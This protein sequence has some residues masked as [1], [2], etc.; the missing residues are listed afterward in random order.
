MVKRIPGWITGAFLLALCLLV[1]YGSGCKE[2]NNS[3][4]I[5]MTLSGIQATSGTLDE[6]SGTFSIKGYVKNDGMPVVNLPVELFVGNKEVASPVQTAGNGQFIF[7]NLGPALYTLRVG[8]GSATFTEMLYPVYVTEDGAQSP[9]DLVIPIELRN[10]NVIPASGTLEAYVVDASTNNPIM[11]A[12]ASLSVYSGGVWVPQNRTTLT[13][14]SGY[15]F[16]SDVLPGLYTL[17][18]QKAGYASMAYPVNLQ[19][20]GAMSPSKPKIPLTF[21]SSVPTITGTISGYAKDVSGKVIP[22]ITITVKDSKTGIQVTGSPR[23]TTTEGKFTFDNLPIGE[24]AI[25]AAGVGYTSVTRTSYIR[26]DGTA[27]P[28]STDL[29]LA[30]ITAITGSL[31]GYVK[32]EN[33]TPL[34]E[35][36]ITVTNINTGL[37]IAGSPRRTTTEGK[38]IFESVPVGDYTV[39]ATGAGYSTA[40]RT[41]YIRSDGTADPVTTQIA[42][43]RVTDIKGTI[44]GFARLDITNAVLPEITVTAKNVG[45]GLF[46]AGSPRKTTSEGRYSFYDLPPGEYTVTASGTGYTEVTRTCYIKTDGAADPPSTDLILS[47]S[48]ASSK[49]EAYVID[50]STNAGIGLADVSLSKYDEDTGLWN[51]LGLNTVTNGSGYFSFSGIDPG[52]YLAAVSKTGYVSRDYAITIKEDG[53]KD[54]A[55]PRITLTS[56]AQAIVGNVVGTVKLDTTGLA[57]PEISVSLKNGSNAHVTGSPLKTTAD[58][59]FGFYG[60]VPG[61]YTLNASGTNYTSVTRTCYILNNGTSDPTSTN[62][63]LSRDPA[64]GNIIGYVKY[65]TAALPEISVTVR[66]SNGDQVASSPFITTQDGK[67][68]AYDLG[69]GVYTISVNAAG[70]LPVTRTVY[71]A[72]NGIVDPATSNISLTPDPSVVGTVIGYVR[73]ASTSAAIPEVDV[74]LEDSNGDPVGGTIKTTSEGK[75]LFENLRPDTYSIIVPGTVAGVP[76]YV[77]VT[78]TCYIRSNGA[79]DPAQTIVSVVHLP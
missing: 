48:M 25:T 16:F 58:G 60:L 7:S 36:T 14:G 54:P 2:G 66:D 79:S 6:F 19:S 38:Y 55:M 44:T 64:T 62:I 32:L 69:A 15:F 34:P 46:V 35:I 49:I 24:Y 77:A 43:T 11:L 59:K 52:L 13:D 17:N 3:T 26:N 5:S 61:T 51:A 72:T 56:V 30:P 29:I 10:P 70:Y 37:A 9:A 39:S 8:H 76:T 53:T 50:A 20:T 45:T 27:D 22:Q 23:V 68:A 47:Y 31:V 4:P 40:T 74:R 28:S 65:G 71:I 67:F 78:R 42:L 18:I 57:I 21:I 75:F 1:I 63:V 73:L 41:C 12:T 33:G